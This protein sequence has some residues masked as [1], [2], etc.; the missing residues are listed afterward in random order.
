MKS[1]WL[2]LLL[3]CSLQAQA[4]ITVVEPWVRTTAPGQKV[5][6]GYLRI[7]SDKDVALVSANSSFADKVE[8][9]EMLMDNGIMKMRPITQL[10]LKANQPVEL[11]PSGLHLMLTGIKTAVKAGDTIPLT[12]VF[13]DK[14]AVKE[15]VS[16]VF[17]GR[18]FNN[19]HKH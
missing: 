7:V 16:I 5:A 1:C 3:L 6:A 17:N 15:A 11:K 18:D 4:E 19:H 14:Q 8:V 13:E 10:I 12:L 9:H 2:S